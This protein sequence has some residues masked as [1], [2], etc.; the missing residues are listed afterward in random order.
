MTKQKI[1]F[2]LLRIVF[3]IVLFGTFLFQSCEPARAQVTFSAEEVLQLAEQNEERKA[4]IEYREIQEKQL[5]SLDL[6][7]QAM[8]SERDLDKKDI[9]EYKLILDDYRS[10][11][12]VRV[13]QIEEYMDQHDQDQK[14]IKKQHRRL[15]FWRIFTPVVVTTAA[16]LAILK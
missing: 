2:S 15:T 13:K 9:E 5:D 8:V 1:T 16:I 4:C 6:K 3:W 10:I 11:D 7:I 12:S 14:I